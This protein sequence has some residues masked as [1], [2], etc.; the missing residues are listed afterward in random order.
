[1]SLIDLVFP[2]T[3]LNCK[4]E[5][6][7]VCRNCAEK[8]RLSIEICPM[9]CRSSVGGVVHIKCKSDFGLDGLTSV[10]KHE[11]VIRKA[12]LALKYKYATEVAKELQCFI[13]TELE[14][15]KFKFLENYYL[16]PVP[17]HWIRENNRGFNQT[18]MLGKYISSELG[19]KFV[20]DLIARNKQVSPQVGLKGDERRKNVTNVFTI[21]QENKLQISRIKNVIIFDDVF[22]TGSTLKEA[23][24]VL[25][26]NG[27]AK[28]WG[29]T[30]AR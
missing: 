24:K 29:L 18:Y 20:P 23:A 11:G 28:V 5:G 7:Y 9:C 15:E 3:C 14:F 8:M 26:M 17:L 1:M 30:V 27:M 13:V 16:V 4:R 19:W 12:I 6:K 25:K 22:T 2:K 10:W 21:K